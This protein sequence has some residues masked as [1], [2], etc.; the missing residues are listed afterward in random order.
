MPEDGPVIEALL[1]RAGLDR[2]RDALTTADF[3]ADG[4]AGLLGPELSAALRAGEYGLVRRRLPDGGALA[5]LVRLFPCRGVEPESAV[6]AALAPLPLADALAAGLLR[7]APGGLAAALDLHPY[8]VDDDT[9][10][11]QTGTTAGT[12][13]TTAGASGGERWW[14]VAD[15]PAETGRGA[16]AEDHVLG[17]GGASTT[18][19]LATVRR[20][21]G[22]ALDLGTGC[23]VQALHLGRHARRVTATDVSRR[24][25]RFAATTAALSGQ[26][27]ELLAGDLA[28]PVAGRRFDLVVSN[29]PFIVG[30][31][32]RDAWTYRDSGRA[33][34]GVTAELI[35][36]AP[37]LLA[38]GGYAQFLANW[39]HPAGGDWADRLA[40]LLAGTGLD[41]WVIQREVTDPL[42]YVRLWRSDT[43]GDDPTGEQTDRW[44]SWFAAQRVA[45]VGFGIVTLRAAGHDQPVVRVEDLRQPTDQPLGAEVAAWF[46]RQDWLRAHGGTY[47]GSGL[48]TARLRAPGTL[49]LHAESRLG[50]DGWAVGT[51][52]FALDG[53]LRWVQE[54]DELVAALV[55]GCTGVLPLGQLL[56]LLAAGNGLDR[57]ALAAAA[58][59]VVAGLVERG[60]LLPAEGS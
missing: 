16:L 21:V 1:D 6:A 31:A 22:T 33:G 48:L 55:A 44:L 45:A 43:G 17:V 12:G 59:P 32:D 23:G 60:V 29:P 2:L 54:T 5:T 50:P 30:P 47:G 49:A 34:D 35:A 40:G 15:L 3:T 20:P 8:G 4:I 18:L 13:G 7:T 58:L 11:R 57:D 26:D 51:R 24:A 46:D 25:L 27:W 41:A 53:G 9:D 56:D 52:R 37:G 36:A 10:H 19:A 39:V 38:D 28:A 42:D 14:V